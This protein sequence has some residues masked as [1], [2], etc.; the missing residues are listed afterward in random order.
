R[1]AR[2][3]GAKGFDYAGPAAVFGEYA[4]LSGHLNSG[5]RDFDISACA[6]IGAVAYEKLQ[7]FQ[8][9]WRKGERPSADPKR[10]FAKGGFFTSDGRARF[11][12]TPY[13]ALKSQPNAKAPFV[14]NTG[15]LRDQWHTMTRTGVSPRLSQHIAE[16]YVEIHPEDAVRVGLKPGGLARV[17]NAHGAVV[18]RAL[19]TEQQQRGVLFAPI[20]WTDQNAS[21]ARVDALVR[22]HVDPV[23]GQ[24]ESKAS[25]VQIEPW[26]AAWYGFALTREKPKTI[27]AGYFALARTSF[28]WRIELAGK[29]E[30]QDWEALARALL[31]CDEATA[32]EIAHI[33]N[34]R[35]GAR[36]WLVTESDRPAGLLFVAREPISASRDF[37]CAEFEKAGTCD[38][39]ALLAG[40]APHGALDRGRTICVCHGVGVTEIEAAIAAHAAADADAVGRLTKAGTGCGSCRPEIQRMLKDAAER[41]PALQRAPAVGALEPAA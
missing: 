15:R 17:S 12:A 24:P 31:G 34:A 26:P 5:E 35:T 41:K 36:R 27:A 8:W 19:V 2:A 21:A 39:R 18:L 6:D 33:Q 16:P 14:L 10:F 32:A 40:R 28:G 9:P 37:L 20:H 7:P 38:A 23:S 11:V 29:K 25:A 3:M 13:R 30:P 4:A 1:V 22:A